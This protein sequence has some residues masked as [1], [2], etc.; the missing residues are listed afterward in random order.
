MDHRVPKT[1]AV[2][3][4]IAVI[5]AA[6]SFVYLNSAFEGPSPGGSIRETYELEAT[7]DD[8]EGLP[9]K[10]SVLTNGVSVG[11]VTDV[12]YNAD[13]VTGTVTFT[14]DDD[15]APVYA[16]ATA[17]IGERTILGD[18]YL[19]LDRGHPEAGELESGAAVES[20]PS[21]DFDEAFDFLDEDGRAHL[22]SLLDTLGEPG[23]TEGNGE[24][25]NGTVGGL[26]RTV[27]ELNTL[28]STLQGQE[29]QIAGLVSDGAVV[30]GE[31]GEREQAIRTIVGSGRVTLDALAA[32]TASL[33]RGLDE[34]PPLLDAGRSS[35]A[36][37]RPLVVEARPFVAKLRA[38]APDLRPVLA[39]LGPLSR[40]GAD[41]IAAL[42]P[43]RVA[44]SPLLKTTRVLLGFTAPLIKQLEPATTNLVSMQRYL[45]PRSDSVAAF[46]ANIASAL[47]HGDSTSKWARFA[48]SPEPG[49]FAD[50]P[51]PATCRPEDDV[52]VNAGLCHNAYPF[53]RDA[54]DPEP[55]EPGSYP[56]LLPYVPPPRP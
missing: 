4:V 49:E 22:Q 48:L 33:Q 9:T 5:I 34:L 44:A 21:V 16:D 19:D 25:L 37:A 2:V 43:F 45:A 36:A 10:R 39:Q 17:R 6:L 8:V 27:E 1:G 46:F 3:S 51:T 31:L 11:K 28:T 30:L 50:A 35:L 29:Q 38:I 7:F 32:D 54:S 41:L 15:F 42:K 20:L 56:R 26:A 23:A 52:A 55:Y 18:P 47:A 12:S 24:R 53:P 13:D 40:D 14:V